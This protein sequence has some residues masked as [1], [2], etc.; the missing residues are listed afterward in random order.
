MVFCSAEQEKAESLWQANHLTSYAFELWRAH[1]AMEGHT[2][3]D[4]QI[5]S[6]S[7]AAVVSGC[8]VAV[9]NPPKTR[10]LALHTMI[11]KSHV[12]SLQSAATLLICADATNRLAARKPPASTPTRT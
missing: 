11:H 12:V 7:V 3:P 6:H 8:V 4:T 5:S 9:H 2:L 1:D 10:L